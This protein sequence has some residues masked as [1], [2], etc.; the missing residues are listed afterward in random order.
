MLEVNVVGQFE[1]PILT[2]LPIKQSELVLNVTYRKNP[3]KG[4]EDLIP[5]V[6]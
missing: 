3:E 6:L 1:Y 5:C 2:T 4:L